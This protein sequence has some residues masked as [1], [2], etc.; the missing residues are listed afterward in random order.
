MK[1]GD[2]ALLV[3][4]LFLL[5]AFGFDERLVF[6]NTHNSKNTELTTYQNS[7]LWLMGLDWEGCITDKYKCNRRKAGEEKNLLIRAEQEAASL[8]LE[9]NI[10]ALKPSKD[11]LKYNL[12]PKMGSVEMSMLK[13]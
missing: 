13:K 12:K 3:F 8:D 5:L 11:Q 1:T 9:L 6:S 4:T 2:V 10:F 7:Q